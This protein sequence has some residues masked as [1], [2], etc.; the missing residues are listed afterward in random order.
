MRG[1]KAQKLYHMVSD[2]TD[3][4]TGANIHNPHAAEEIFGIYKLL[5]GI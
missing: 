1:L 2:S 5:Y 4:F 3:V